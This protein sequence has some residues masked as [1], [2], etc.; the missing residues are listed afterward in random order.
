[1]FVTAVESSM[2]LLWVSLSIMIAFMSGYLH[3]KRLLTTPATSKV[4]LSNLLVTIIANLPSNDITP[5]PK[6]NW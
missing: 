5:E 4:G 2:R 3:L 6:I 1:M